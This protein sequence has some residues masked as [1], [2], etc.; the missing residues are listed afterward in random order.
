MKGGSDNKWNAVVDDCRSRSLT[1]SSDFLHAM[2]GLV[3]RMQELGAGE[4][5]AGL[6]RA[7]L[8]NEILW[9]F[10]SMASMSIPGKARKSAKWF[11][12]QPYQAPI[13]SWASLERYDYNGLDYKFDMLNHSRSLQ[14]TDFM[15]SCR[16]PNSSCTP[17]SH[18]KNGAVISGYITIEGKLMEFV[19]R[20]RAPDGDPVLHL[21]DE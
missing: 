5:L 3:S 2:S 13:W 18:D 1:Y 11:R 20:E 19:C 6:W 12:S 15:P 17:P 16:I 4:Y 21:H 9:A 8:I 14:S 7:Q 10:S